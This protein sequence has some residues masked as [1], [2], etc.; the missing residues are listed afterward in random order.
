MKVLHVT[1]LYPYDE[2]PTYGIFVKEQI[3]SLKNKDL[4]DVF[5]INAKKF[6]IKEYFNSIKLL[7]KI[8]FNYDIIHCHHQ[9]STI[10]VLFCN[11]RGK[12][13]LSILGDISK[14]TFSNRLVFSIVKRFCSKVIFKN[15]LPDSSPKNVLIPNGVNLDLFKPIDQIESKKHLNL[16]L[17]K[18][19]ILF[20]CNGP[21][22]NPI[23]RHDKFEAVMKS[24]KEDMAKG[25]D[26]E[27]LYLSN[28]SRENVP[29][30][31]NAAD[32]MLLT[33]DHEGSPNA[34]KEAMACNLP[35]VSTSVGDVPVLLK[36][37][38][39]SYISNRGSIEDLVKLSCSIDINDR[40][41]GRRKLKDLGLDSE[42]IATKL[43][44]VYDDVY[45]Q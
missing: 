35:I 13:V 27:T 11:P 3:N 21:L 10:T 14:R 17:G 32:F 19:Y 24:L 22:D 7:R 6:G 1:N 42:S 20:V 37:V 16:D 9:F 12:L 40:S 15:K 33:S 34:I 28:V 45:H 38:N 39:N 44:E 5:F 29:Y 26:Y 23:K 30:Y 31:F 8:I 4:Q 36:E 25:I 2:A 43:K 18:I 41:N